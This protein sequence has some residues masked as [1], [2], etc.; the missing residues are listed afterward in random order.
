MKEQNRMFRAEDGTELDSRDIHYLATA[1][2]KD[3]VAE[4]V[5]AALAPKTCGALL[6]V[7][8]L[9]N[10]LPGVP[11]YFDDVPCVL[12]PPVNGY[13]EGHHAFDP[14]QVPARACPRPDPTVCHYGADACNKPESDPVHWPGHMPAREAWREQ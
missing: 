11:Y 8:T 4:K 10:D 2:M 1:R 12:P 6:R 7:R 5:L 9:R 14:C 3:P 13:H